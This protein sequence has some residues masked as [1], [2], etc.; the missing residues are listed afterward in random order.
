MPKTPYK[1]ELWYRAMNT[2][3]PVAKNGY[4]TTRS[5]SDSAV[6]FFKKYFKNFYYNLIE[7]DKGYKSIYLFLNLINIKKLYIN[8]KLGTF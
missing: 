4:D 1:R 8:L 2:I 7:L 3:A 6:H 5:K